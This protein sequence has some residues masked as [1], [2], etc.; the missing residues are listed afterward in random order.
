MKFYNHDSP[1]IN[2]HL[3][4]LPKFDSKPSYIS[5]LE[6]MYSK[7]TLKQLIKLLNPQ[8]IKVPYNKSYLKGL[9]LTLKGRLKGA[10]R[11]RKMT[12]H[13]G[14]IGPNTY[15]KRSKSNQQTI[16]TKWGTWNLKTS[17][18]RTTNLQHRH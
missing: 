6:K 12:N 5:Q 16:Y 9:Q 13:H 1:I 2:E 8:I 17:L 11:A 10:R 14:S 7:M 4:S 15:S 3:L 18:S